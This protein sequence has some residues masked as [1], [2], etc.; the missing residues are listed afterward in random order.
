MS[1]Y[2]GS[3]SSHVISSSS[4]PSE[5]NPKGGLNPTTLFSGATSLFCWSVNRSVI[6]GE[7]KMLPPHR[8]E[9]SP[10][11]GGQLKVKLPLT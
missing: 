3:T 9:Q 4:G 5:V 1:R 2:K 7:P 10:R 6:R 11:L 8:P